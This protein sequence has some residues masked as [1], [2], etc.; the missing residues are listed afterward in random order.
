MAKII[1]EHRNEKG[2]LHRLDGPAIIY[3]NGTTHWFK[4][5]KKHRDGDLPAV[6]NTSGKTYWYKNGKRHRDGG[7]AV[8]SKD[9]TEW[10][11]DGK[12][13][14]DGNLPAKEWYDGRHREYYVNGKLH[15]TDGPAKEGLYYN[16]EPYQEF[17]LNDVRYTEEEYTLRLKLDR[18]K[19]L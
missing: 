10:Y 6:E 14:R 13:H 9:L 7:P 3:D 18:L 12:K 1:E 15:R 2:Q 8:I 17:Y 16:D 5:N 4:N 11:K 19:Q